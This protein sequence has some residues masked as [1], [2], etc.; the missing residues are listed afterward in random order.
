[1]ETRTSRRLEA[2]IEDMRYRT[3]HRIRILTLLAIP[4]LL[5]GLLSLIFFIYLTTDVRENLL[6]VSEKATFTAEEA[7]V[8][9]TNAANFALKRTD[10]AVSDARAAAES[11]RTAADR[12]LPILSEVSDVISGAES[13]TSKANEAT[14]QAIAATR[15]ANSAADSVEKTERMILVINQ[16]LTKLA[17]IREDLREELRKVQSNNSLMESRISNFEDFIAQSKAEYDK[18]K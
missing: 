12:L 10:E 18:I 6:F 11:A 5:L 9:A 14:Q 15:R 2:H 17:E 7:T 3:G 8:A 4:I 16:E 13:V 1:M